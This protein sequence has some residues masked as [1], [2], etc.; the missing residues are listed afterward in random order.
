VHYSGTLN[1]NGAGKKTTGSF[2]NFNPRQCKKLK[3][4]KT[5]TN[6]NARPSSLSATFTYSRLFARHAAAI[7][8]IAVLMGALLV[9]T[10]VTRADNLLWDW[11][12]ATGEGSS[13]FAGAGTITTTS[14]ANADSYYTI[15]GIT[16]SFTSLDG[17]NAG[18]YTITGLVAPGGDGAF[19]INLNDNL[20]AASY[21]Q[22][23][24][25]AGVAF[26]DSSG[27]IDAIISSANNSPD[28][29]R[30]YSDTSKGVI[31]YDNTGTFTATEVGPVQT[32]EPS[33]WAMML[34]GGL[35][36]V[37]FVRRK[38]ALTS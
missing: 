12:Y 38:H 28:S 30:A 6:L 25:Y 4:M 35:S 26:M 8:K 37:F 36:L 5:L 10:S 32:P 2:S 21:P 18:T 20:L 1:T 23:T 11:T 9:S 19:G 16:G 24:N 34:L 7:M 13:L 22:L 14:T 3:N 27:A 31:S 29:Y 33:T 17:S 15:N